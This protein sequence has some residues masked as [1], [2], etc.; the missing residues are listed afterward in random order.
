[1]FELI[2]VQHIE[3]QCLALYL[4]DTILYVCVNLTTNNIV[5]TYDNGSPQVLIPLDDKGQ[6]KD[7]IVYSYNALGD[8]FYISYLAGNLQITPVLVYIDPV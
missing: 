1:M 2:E 3:K 7:T 4:M 6:V 8:R 5:V